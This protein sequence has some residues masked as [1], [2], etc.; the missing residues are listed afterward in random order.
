MF[1]VANFWL[2]INLKV[3]ECIFVISHKASLKALQVYTIEQLASLTG[4]P[5]KNIGAGGLAH[6][7][8]FHL[9]VVAVLQAVEGVLCDKVRESVTH[10]HGR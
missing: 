6:H 9:A 8:P 2:V 3:C 5:L 4:Q 7:G 1:T 10:P